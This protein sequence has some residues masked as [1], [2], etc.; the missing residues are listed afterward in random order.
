MISTLARIAWSLAL[1][2]ASF[3]RAAPSANSFAVLSEAR[4]AC[5][6]GSIGLFSSVRLPDCEG[7]MSSSF[8]RAEISPELARH[9]PSFMRGQLSRDLEGSGRDIRVRASVLEAGGFLARFIG[10]RECHLLSIRVA[11]R[12]FLVAAW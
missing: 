12:P 4:A 8:L 6:I 2:A 3:A 7:F 9:S 10:W 5:S 11:V 1:A